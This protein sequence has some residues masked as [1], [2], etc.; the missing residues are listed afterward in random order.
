MLVSIVIPTYKRNALVV[1]AVR[2]CLAQHGIDPSER[3]VIVIDNSA[4]AGARDTILEHFPQSDI[5]YIHE[6]TPGVSH[7]RNTGVSSATGDYVAFLDDDEKATPT[8]LSSL[9]VHTQN[10]AV[11]VFGPVREYVDEQFKDVHDPQTV[12][13]VQRELDLPNGAD[14]TDYYHYLGTGNSLFSRDVCFK[15]EHPFSLDFNEGGGEDIH[16][17]AQLRN[18][19]LKLIWAADAWVEE[20]VP[21][22]RLTLGYQARRRFRAGQGRTRVEM[23]RP[24]I[25]LFLA[26]FWIL[27][28]FTQVIIYS[29][30]YLCSLLVFSPNRTYLTKIAGGAGKVLFFLGGKQDD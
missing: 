11:A 4:H 9:L 15:D 12:P 21:A 30:R 23:K 1:E 13:I 17:L 26:L 18:R 14:A 25:G 8:W 6:A 2:S 16:F 10:G 22:S 28:G 19:G 3:E 29:F 24:R 5:R 27:A 20:Y 7:A